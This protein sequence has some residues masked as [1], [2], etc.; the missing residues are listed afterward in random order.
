MKEKQRNGEREG[1]AVTPYCKSDTKERKGA[2]GEPGEPQTTCSTV[3]RKLGPGCRGGPRHTAPL[4]AVRHVPPRGGGGGS[5]G[6]ARLRPRPRPRRRLS[7]PPGR[8][9]RTMG[10]RADSEGQK[11]PLE[12]KRVTRRGLGAGSSGPATVLRHTPHRVGDPVVPG[13]LR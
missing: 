7:A 12:V 4:L 13:H 6:A 8:Q 11:R 5:P 10:A 1:E 3:L 2:R 9:L